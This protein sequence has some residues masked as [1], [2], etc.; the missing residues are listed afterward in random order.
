[1]LADEL[2]A[3]ARRMLERMSGIYEKE[4]GL[5]IVLL[6]NEALQS[7]LHHGRNTKDREYKQCLVRF[8]DNLGVEHKLSINAI[9]KKGQY[10][11]AATNSPSMSKGVTSPH[12]QQE[13]QERKSV[14]G[15]F[16]ENAIMG[17]KP[18]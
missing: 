1:M 6:D 5:R 16:D 7:L 18:E 9:L 8:V 4:R 17:F 14:P 15:F 13:Q 3:I 2:N 12:E 10:Q 11:K